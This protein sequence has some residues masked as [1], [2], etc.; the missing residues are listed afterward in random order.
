MISCRPGGATVT[1]A[2]GEVE[3]LFRKS[4]VGVLAGFS[5]EEFAAEIVALVH[6]RTAASSGRAG[7]EGHGPG[8]GLA[9]SRAADC[10]NAGDLI[11][12]LHPI[13]FRNTVP[14]RTLPERLVGVAATACGATAAGLFGLAGAFANW[15]ANSTSW[16][17]FFLALKPLIDLMWRWSFFR[18]S[19]QDVN[20]QAVVG[21]AVLSLNGVAVLKN[22]AWRRLPRRVM[23]LLAFASLSV[24][25]SPSSWAVNELVRL[26]AGTTFFYTAGPL[27]AEPRQLIAS[28]RYRKAR[29][30]VD[31]L[32]VYQMAN[33]IV[34]APRTG[35]SVAA[36]QASGKSRRSVSRVA[37]V[38]VSTDK[39]SSRK[40]ALM[41]PS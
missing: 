9:R 5:D 28:Q 36:V 24:V 15:V 7:T 16:V 21:L 17:F 23:L 10:R 2:V 4:D 39:H 19:E 14:R 3:T 35:P 26:L 27:L 25:L 12:G 40:G 13:P 29:H 6:A 8:M 30:P 11:W 38:R 22:A 32:A 31:S 20:T 1:N 18:F 37:G 33:H 41:N 34:R